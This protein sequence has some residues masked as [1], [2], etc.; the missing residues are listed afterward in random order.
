MLLKKHVVVSE[1][2]GA[3]KKLEL[4]NNFNRLKKEKRLTYTLQNI[5]MVNPKRVINEFISEVAAM[6]DQIHSIQQIVTN[7]AI[8]ID[9]IVKHEGVK[10]TTENELL[11]EKAKH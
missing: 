3:I 5:S 10:P 8:H 1:F 7:V 11:R 9:D 4:E 6:R 2:S